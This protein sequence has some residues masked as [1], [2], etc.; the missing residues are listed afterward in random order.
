MRLSKD[1]QK[2]LLHTAHQHFGNNIKM[3]LFGSRTDDSKKGGDIDLFIE[4]EKHISLQQQVLLLKDVYKYITQ[5]K[6]DLIVKTP[7]K[8]ERSIHQTARMEGIQ[9][10]AQNKALIK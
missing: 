6:V 4:S 10:L 9:L 1:I 3:Y 2:K 7:S 5:R 8:S